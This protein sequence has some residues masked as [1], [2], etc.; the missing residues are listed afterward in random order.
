MTQTQHRRLLRTTRIATVRSRPM[1]AMTR[2]DHLPRCHRSLVR[3]H[4]PRLRHLRLRCRLRRPR[5]E[6]YG[7][8]DC[9]D[10]NPDVTPEPPTPPTTESSILNADDYDADADGAVL[11]TTRATTATTP[12]RRSTSAEEIG[13]TASTKTGRKHA[14]QDGDGYD[15]AKTATM[16]TPCPTRTT[17][18]SM[19]T[20]WRSQKA[21]AAAQDTR[22]GALGLGLADSSTQKE[23]PQG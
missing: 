2:C 15:K 17:A 23:V 12:T 1:T 18:H 20:A 11:R 6:T 16:R 10:A 21:D 7:G 3:R 4:R 8:E 13:T 5:P 22:Q 9:D 14:D 19:Q